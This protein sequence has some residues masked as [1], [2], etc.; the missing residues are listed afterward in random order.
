MDKDEE[1]KRS[2]EDMEAEVGS[3]EWGRDHVRVFH[4]TSVISVQTFV[5]SEGVSISVLSSVQDSLRPTISGSSRLIWE[6]VTETRKSSPFRST[7][8]STSKR[9][10]VV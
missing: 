1:T 3:L 9:R 2:M 4:S 6:N 5:F 10:K 8:N 7:S